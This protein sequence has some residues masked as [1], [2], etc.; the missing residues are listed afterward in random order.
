ML[1]VIFLNPFC[2]KKVVVMLVVEGILISS[3]S[4]PGPSTDVNSGSA[5]FYPGTA[6]RLLFLT[7]RSFSYGKPSEPKLSSARRSESLELASTQS[8]ERM[9][10]FFF[11]S[12]LVYLKTLSSKLPIFF[13]SKF[14]V[15]VFRQG[16]SIES[17]SIDVSLL[18]NC[19]VPP[20]LSSIR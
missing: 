3:W 9:K 2:L 11:S 20:K 19:F 10:I 16:T 13:S 6:F 7:T 1:S 14:V 15:K 5:A 4:K 12:S 17:K 18:N 8:V